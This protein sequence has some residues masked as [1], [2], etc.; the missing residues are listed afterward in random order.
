MKLAGFQSTVVYGFLTLYSLLAPRCERSLV[1]LLATASSVSMFSTLDFSL[2]SLMRQDI[3][4]NSQF[5]FRSAAWTCSL[6]DFRFCCSLT[7]ALKSVSQ[8]ETSRNFDWFSVSWFWTC[9]TLEVSDCNVSSRCWTMDCLKWT[10]L[11]AKCLQL[12]IFTWSSL[13]VDKLCEGTCTVR[14][15][16]HDVVE[17]PPQ[18]THQT[19]SVSTWFDRNRSLVVTLRKSRHSV[20]TWQILHLITSLWRNSC[21]SSKSTAE[22]AYGKISLVTLTQFWQSVWLHLSSWRHRLW[23]SKSSSHD[24]H[25]ILVNLHVRSVHLNAT[26]IYRLSV[27]LSLMAWHK[28]FISAHNSIYTSQSNVQFRY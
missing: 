6:N 8:W 21:S 17:G 11:P 24:E 23:S 18:V 12:S 5:H 28:Q 9:S 16:E 2:I 14:W 10:T 25:I 3:S 20:V 4:W 26:S 27:M 13:Q 1:E 22:F 15:S 7:A 19:I